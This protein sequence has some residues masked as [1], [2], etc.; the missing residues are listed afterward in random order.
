M[1]F[2]ED[3]IA[4]IESE[5]ESERQAAEAERQAAIVREAAA[6]MVEEQ[7][8][9]ARREEY[10][11]YARNRHDE[12]LAFITPWF[13]KVGI[14]PS[15]ITAAVTKWT[16]ATSWREQLDPVKYYIY[17]RPAKTT[18]TWAIEGYKFIADIVYP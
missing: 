17:Y 10:Q 13:T 8:A 2:R 7:I 6:K 18:L 14:D 16:N 15:T 11:Q 12:A 3:A 9:E 5:R 1:G 4:A